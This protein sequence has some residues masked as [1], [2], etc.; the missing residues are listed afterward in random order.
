MK[1]KYW[2]EVFAGALALVCIFVAAFA[3]FSEES[4]AQLIRQPFGAIGEWIG[5]SVRGDN[6]AGGW[7]LYVFMGL[8]PLVY[9]AVRMAVTR[10]FYKLSPIWLLLSGYT[11]AMLYLIAYPDILASAVFG[12]EAEWVYRIATEGGMSVL[13]AALL[14]L[15]VLV[16]CIAAVR[17][18]P[19]RSYPLTQAVIYLIA[20]GFIVA[21]CFGG[22]Y[23]ARVAVDTAKLMDKLGVGRVG[24]DYFVIVFRLLCNM[25]ATGAV[26]WM[27]LES[28]KT[29]RTMKAD[30]FGTDVVPRLNRLSRAAKGALYVGLGSSI[31]SNAVQL[32]LSKW[33]FTVTYT[34]AFSLTVLL[35]VCLVVIAAEVM[36]RA[37]AA[38]EENQLTV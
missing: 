36:K 12:E 1:F 22:V 26:V 16:E 31:V 35:V 24:L 6:A 28:L 8:L 18:R 17:Q 11:Y 15:C 32:A 13:W 4:A 29:L 30:M 25:A 34:V 37:I 21:V 10:R 23:D 14:A 20:A 33:L 27:L 3:G 38:H 9:P 5:K 2:D 7:A 19:Q